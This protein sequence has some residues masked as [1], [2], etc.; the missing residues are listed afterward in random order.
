[1]STLSRVVHCAVLCVPVAQNFLSA[2][3]C[4][5]WRGPNIQSPVNILNK[6]R[7]KGSKKDVWRCQQARFIRGFM[8]RYSGQKGLF[9]PHQAWRSG[10][11]LSP[12]PWHLTQELGR[13]WRIR[14]PFVE[15]MHGDC[16]ARDSQALTASE[17]PGSLLKKKNTYTWGPTQTYS[18]LIYRLG[19]RHQYF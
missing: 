7:R 16:Y 11:L 9:C 5:K 1:M 8:L 6:V 2:V 19:S 17:S 10:W 15:Q 14:E 13:Q 12:H 4:W 18:I 3:A